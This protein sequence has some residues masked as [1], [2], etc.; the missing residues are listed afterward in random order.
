MLNKKTRSI[1]ITSGKGGVGKSSLA[2]N[3]GLYLSRKGKKVLIFD[4]DLGMANIDIMFGQKVQRNVMDLL[5]DQYSI[6]DVLTRLSQNL[7]LI[8]GGS[9]LPEIQGLNAYQKKC[10]ID[11]MSELEGLFDYLLIDT[12][13]GIDENVRLLNSSA[14]EIFVV[15]TPEPASLTDAYALIKVLHLVQ[16]EKNFK[17][18]CNQV[19]SER[20]G[21]RLYEMLQKVCDQFLNINLEHIASIQR[22]QAFAQATRNQELVLNSAPEAPSA[23]QVR[24]LADKIS[25]YGRLGNLKGSMQF[26]MGVNQVDL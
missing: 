3:L 19:R 23:E 9:A 20:D 25:G 14:G 7:Y 8:S 5:S 10:I 15:L 26:F 17:I 4:G 11:Q 21:V 18:I 16:K 2:A 12:P 1:S 24:V 6:D 13:P 22:D